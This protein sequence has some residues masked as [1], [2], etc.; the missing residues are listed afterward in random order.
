MHTERLFAQRN[1]ISKNESVSDKKPTEV[2]EYDVYSDARFTG[3]VDLPDCPYAFLNALSSES[4]TVDTRMV[5]RIENYDDPLL[6]PSID[7]SKTDDATYHGGW[8]DDEI[9]SLASVILGVRLA[10]GGTSRRWSR[11]FD[12]PYG[13]PE[14]FTMKPKMPFVTRGGGILPDVTGEHSMMN[15]EHFDSIL[16][17]DPCRF[18]SLVRACSLYRNALWMVELDANLAW[19]LFVS[20]LETGVR[21]VYGP[22]NV[23]RS[24][25][26]FVI[27]FRPHAPK[28]RPSADSLQFEWTEEN[29]MRMLE[30]IY[31]YRSRALHDGKPFPA[32]MVDRPW[33]FSHG[34]PPI[35]VPGP[36]LAVSTM[37]G[38]WR[39][40][41][42]PI[43]L[44]M[45]HYITRHVLLNWWDRELSSFAGTQGSV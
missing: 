14:R 33:Q 10:S 7:W 25:A 26:K 30:L 36:G 22:G 17:I 45:F 40:E 27:R 8:Y 6:S 20:A 23:T 16:H 32:P 24:F 39:K 21:D 34:V 29:F 28:Q 15:L 1:W 37:G 43:N 19:L 11:P 4:G 5:L 2:T 38:T 35:E 13:Q 41:E 44:H 3:Q 9:I 12:D 31:D 18:V 42:L